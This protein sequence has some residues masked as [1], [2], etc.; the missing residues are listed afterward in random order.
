MIIKVSKL[1][2]GWA[3]ITI[4]PVIL[5]TTLSEAVIRHEKVHVEQWKKSPILFIPRYLL[6]KQYRLRCE[7]EAYKTSLLHGMSFTTAVQHLL[8]YKTGETEEAI[9]KLLR[10]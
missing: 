4:G 1:W 9:I 7:I 6:D 2:G 10:G 5:T 3:A 8:K